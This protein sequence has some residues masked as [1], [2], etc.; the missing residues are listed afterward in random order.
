M[1]VYK[2]DQIFDVITDASRDNYPF[3]LKGSIKMNDGELSQ[4]NRVYKKVEQLAKSNE[5]MVDKYDESFKVLFSGE[6]IKFTTVADKVKRSIYGTGCKVFKN[7][8]EY[9]ELCFIPTANECFR[10]CVEYIYNKDFS[11]E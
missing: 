6:M 4:I 9:R 3:I 10:K 5:K 1:L 2:N 8:L 11:R 7:I